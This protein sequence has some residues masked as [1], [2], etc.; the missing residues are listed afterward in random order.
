MLHSTKTQKSAL[1]NRAGMKKYIIFALG[2]ETDYAMTTM[3]D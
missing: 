2:F 3:Q 1:K